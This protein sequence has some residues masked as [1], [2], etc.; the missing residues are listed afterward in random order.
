ML[1]ILHIDVIMLFCRTQPHVDTVHRLQNNLPLYGPLVRCTPGS[2]YTGHLGPMPLSPGPMPRV[3]RYI[4]TLISC[5]LSWSWQPGTNAT[6]P[7]PGTPAPFWRVGSGKWRDDPTKKFDQ[8][9]ENKN[10][11]VKVQIN[12][13]VETEYIRG[14]SYQAR[15]A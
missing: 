13:R 12:D 1:S 10:T 7:W 4:K 15:A 5:L 8:N 14:D 6:Q 11:A 9:S 3:T 2:H